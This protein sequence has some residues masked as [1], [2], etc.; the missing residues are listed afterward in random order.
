MVIYVSGL[1]E[2]VKGYDFLFKQCYIW[3]VMIVD[4][5]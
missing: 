1:L 5:C 2:I 4:D 3:N